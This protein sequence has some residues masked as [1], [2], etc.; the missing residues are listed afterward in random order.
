MGRGN[1]LPP[2]GTAPPVAEHHNEAP[3]LVCPDRILCLLTDLRLDNG[4]E[5]E[6][7]FRFP[8]CP[9]AGR[10]DGAR[11]LNALKTGGLDTLKGIRGAFAG[12]LWH[13]RDHQLHLFRDPMGERPLF[14]HKNSSHVVFASSLKKL[15]SYP[16]TH[17]SPNLDKLGDYLLF[18][19]SSH[20]DTP[21]R[22]IHRVPPGTIVSFDSRGGVTERSF[23]EWNASVGITFSSKREYAEALRE[24]LEIAVSRRIGTEKAVGS[25]LSSGLDSSAV[26]CIAAN[27]LRLRGKPLHS[28]TWVPSGKVRTVAGRYSDESPLA[29]AIARK[30]ANI[31]LSL[32]SSPEQIHTTRLDD[33]WVF[34]E[35][36]NPFPMN[37]WYEE[38]MKQASLMG[39]GVML[40]GFKGN[41]S[42]SHNS[43]QSPSLLLKQFRPFR[44][45]T[46]WAYCLDF[47][48]ALIHSQMRGALKLPFKRLFSG[49][50]AGKSAGSRW[51]DYTVAR[52]DYLKKSG[53]I[54]RAEQ[55]RVIAFLDGAPLDPFHFR[56]AAAVGGDCHADYWFHLENKYG[57]V[58]RDPTADMDLLSFC[59]ALPDE[60]FIERGVAKRAVSDLLPREVLCNRQRGYQNGDWQHRFAASLPEL[61]RELSLLEKSD[62][63]NEILDLKKIKR[64]LEKWPPGDLMSPG[65]FA[66]Y[67]KAVVNGLNIGKYIRRLERFCG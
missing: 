46:Q 41:F 34:M 2:Y 37:P 55:A 40:T 21:F 17:R 67:E 60:Q 36:P 6:R 16:D 8:S 52:S 5:L 54:E 56:H 18:N 53:T 14:Y 65:T 39:I 11:V 27:R 35:A 32:V 50:R 15:F 47:N 1:L 30:N 61:M 66:V 29:R 7:A 43:S 22:N 26:S 20:A 13:G 10:T 4:P 38:I 12:A 59:L 45:L 25:H 28:F 42:F 62:L 19:Q 44:I 48:R 57:V 23:H 51:H 33:E 58:M 31:D 3:P 24:R 64:M 49:R 9:E 63:A